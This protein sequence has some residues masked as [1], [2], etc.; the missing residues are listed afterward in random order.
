LMLPGARRPARR[1]RRTLRWASLVIC[2]QIAGLVWLAAL[3]ESGKFKEDASAREVTVVLH[4]TELHIANNGSVLDVV[5]RMDGAR[6]GSLTSAPQKVRFRWEPRSICAIDQQVGAA[7]GGDGAAPQALAGS[8][9]PKHN[10]ERFLV[11]SPQFGLSNQIVALRNAAG[12]ASLLNRTLVVP[13]LVNG[14]PHA[15]SLTMIHHGALFDMHS[16]ARRLAPALRVVEMRDF[17]GLGL[18]PARLVQLSANTKFS[19]P[20]YDYLDAIGL[21]SWHNDGSAPPLNIAMSSFI[22]STIRGLF[23]GCTHH[24]LLAFVSLFGAFDPKPLSKGPGDWMIPAAFG[25]REDGIHFLDTRAMPSLLTPNKP[26]ARLVEEIVAFIK[27]SASPRMEVADVGAMRRRD[28]S[29]EGASSVRLAC[30]HVRRGDFHESC[31]HY[32][33]EARSGRAR[34]W[35]VSHFER[36]FS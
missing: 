28:A 13:H 11:Y 7:T 27:K 4:H 9:D 3:G 36:G 8:M 14:P 2:A 32:E 1:T 23:A 15:A 24:R 6:H 26:V 29:A 19:V 25:T 17:L 35:V 12:W 21:S 22:P 34:Q 31:M 20:S 33:E 10:E 16:A 18:T 30:V 5:D